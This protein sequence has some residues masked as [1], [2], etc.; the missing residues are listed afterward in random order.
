M[1]SFTEIKKTAD[2]YSWELYM[3]SNEG[4][5]TK[6]LHHKFLNTTRKVEKLQTNAIKFEGGSWLYFP[7][8]EA[9]KIDKY[10]NNDTDIILTIKEDNF[11][12]LGYHLRPLN[13]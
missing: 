7:K 8:A 11:P 2:K 10:L 13:N 12:V 5:P 3:F 9:V 1:K 6:N 4:I